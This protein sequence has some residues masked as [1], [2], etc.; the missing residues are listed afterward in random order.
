MS[1]HDKPL[2]DKE[3]A[4]Y[5]VLIDAAIKRKNEDESMLKDVGLSFAGFGYLVA[6][7]TMDREYK[8]RDL[9]KR[10]DGMSERE[11]FNLLISN[12]K[13]L[14]H[15]TDEERKKDDLELAC[16]LGKKIGRNFSSTIGESTGCT[17]AE[18]ALNAK[19]KIKTE[20]REHQE[21]DTAGRAGVQIEKL[22]KDAYNNID[23]N[24]LRWQKEANSGLE[25]A[26]KAFK[27]FACDVGWYSPE[28]CWTPNNHIPA[29]PAEQKGRKH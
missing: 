18:S 23:K 7:D 10:K 16:E 15:Q 8:Y 20:F 13:R 9:D 12:E 6:G 25:N 11:H 1:N 26:I 28:K 17:Y 4:R 21:A 24:H 5:Q 29:P 22:G 3:R 2:S 19:E 27:N 14:L